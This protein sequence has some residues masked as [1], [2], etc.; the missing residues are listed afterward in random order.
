MGASTALS[1]EGTWR[2]TIAVEGLV[3][4]VGFRPFVYRLARAHALAGS[5]RNGRGGV[6]IDVEGDADALTRFLEQ[7]RSS[8]PA[9]A[10][11]QRV[12]VS[13][14]A[15]RRE[16]RP[17]TIA[18]SE[19]DG[20]PALFPAPDLATCEACLRDLR[21]PADRRYGYPFLNCTACGPRF[22]IIRALPYDRERTSMA[23]FTMCR[24][25][26]DE[27]DDPG[28]RR[29]HAEPTACSV[30]GPRL[31][32]LGADGRTLALGA[33]LETLVADLRSGKIA[34]IKGLGGYHL[35]CDATS[36]TAVVELR[37]RKGRQAKPL[38][39][40]VENLHVA[41]ELCVISSEEADLLSSPARPIVLLEKRPSPTGPA[42]ADGVAPGVRELGLMLPY[43]P[44]HHR[45]LE[46]ARVPL[47]M[48]SGNQSDEPIA[49]EDRDAL[50]RLGGLA[51]R[52]LVHDRPIQV[53]CD[54]S[55][56]RIVRGS[57]LLLRRARGHV[58]LAITLPHEAT[59]PILA[60]GGELKSVFALVRG[61]NAFMSQH[62]GDLGDERAWRAWLGAVAHF[63]RLLDLSPVVIVHDLH[64]GYRP[65]LYAESL[66]GVERRAVQHHHAHIASCLADNGV[67]TRVIGVAWDGT[68]YGIDG[69]VWGGEF[70]VADLSGFER[71]GHLEEVAMPGGAAAIREPWRMAAA[72][73][74]CAYGEAMDAL[75]CDFVRRL[76]RAAWR[77]LQ[78]AAQ[79]GLNAPLTSSAGRL[80]DAVAS[81]LGLRDTV[82]FEAQAAIELE[83]L[84]EPGSDRVYPVGF[85]HREG[86]IVVRTSDLVRGIVEDLLA[87]TPPQR[88]A[89]RFHA[90]L[91]DVIAGVCGLIRDRT[92]LSRAALSGGV[93]QNMRLLQAAADRL[94][95]AG[96]EVYTH[97]QVPPND[98][99]LALGQ[100]AVAARLEAGRTPD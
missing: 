81:L 42:V 27:Y 86:Q 85:D 10:R 80:F 11:P 22:T 30:C 16:A 2:C 33:P 48:T 32:L 45:L 59:R 61:R 49:Y 3:Q 94:E 70:L 71:V 34:A 23:G 39:V 28:D 38:A 35:A 46:L 54:D 13:W 68:G 4:G 8:A 55:V 19:C 97:H 91:A 100:A 5:V 51:D 47:V 21:D 41:R 63:E 9:V 57:P 31:A 99:G 74:F 26:R 67:D 25:C 14:G 1:R 87:E 78:R 62:L 56:A 58:P 79:R 95:Q 84:S 98:G 75:D 77:I 93:F 96:F 92:G 40:M 7:I 64:P 60:C 83:A 76:D 69:R 12:I 53:R 73:L 37:R 88:I 29:F 43:T 18:E 36:A 15:P 17:F 6:V 89:A 66:E 24:S 72:H 52:F 65:T 90:T 50:A 82:A 20:E 44:L